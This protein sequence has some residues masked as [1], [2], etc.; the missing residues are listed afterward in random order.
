MLRAN[1]S[2][3][4]LIELVTVIVILGILAALALPRFARVTE[5]AHTAA[6]EGASGGLAAGVTLARAQW[7]AN[8]HTGAVRDLA[9]FGRGQVDVGNQGWPTDAGSLGGEI[10][11]AMTPQRC[12]NVWEGVM[13][14]ASPPVATTAGREVDYVA[15]VVE[16]SDEPGAGNDNCQFIYQLDDSGRA[17][18]YDADSG[19]VTR[20]F[21]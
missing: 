14:G 3:F 10:S 11:P 1:E 16:D 20:T 2:G 6:I 5:Q 4:T 13:Q 12:I 8:G 21:Q 17:I 19:E 7:V 9:G 15:S 18:I